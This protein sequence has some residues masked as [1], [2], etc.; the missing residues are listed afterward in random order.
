MSCCLVPTVCKVVGITYCECN[1]DLEDLCRAFLEQYVLLAFIEPLISSCLVNIDEIGLIKICYSDWTYFVLHTS[2]NHRNWELLSRYW[3]NLGAHL[4]SPNHKNCFFGQLTQKVFGTD[5]GNNT[6]LIAN[7]MN[8]I[9]CFMLIFAWPSSILS[10]CYQFR[11]CKP[12]C[13][14]KCIGQRNK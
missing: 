6:W 12:V 8:V 4:T 11:S 14:H 1:A 13:I 5:W 9:C 3:P 7:V 10:S 2:P